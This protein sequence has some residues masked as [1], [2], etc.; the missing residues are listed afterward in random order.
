MVLVGI[1]PGACVQTPLESLQ[2]HSVFG[3]AI[4]REDWPE[5]SDIVVKARTLSLGL[6]GQVPCCKLR[7][8]TSIVIVLLV[9]SSFRS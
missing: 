7:N 1:A 8:S 5:L 2:K 3:R 4:T 6:V 9:G